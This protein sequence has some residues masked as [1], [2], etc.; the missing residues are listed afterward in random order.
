MLAREQ[1]GADV[2]VFS[3]LFLNGYPPED[4]VLKPAFQDATRVEL[5]RLAAACAEGPAVLIGT[6]WR[7]AGKVY[8]RRRAARRRPH[9]GRHLQ[10]GIAELR[11]LRRK[12][13]LRRRADAGSA[14]RARRPTWRRDL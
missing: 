8:Q 9:R 3:E 2:I 11:R 6:I 12:A 7:D 5:E 4:L 13:R 14:E 1:A 10:V